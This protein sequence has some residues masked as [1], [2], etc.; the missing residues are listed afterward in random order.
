MRIPRVHLDQPLQSGKR[1][2]LDPGPA[3][4]LLKVLRLRPGAKLALFNGDGHDYPA[5]LLGGGEVQLDEAVTMHS[6]S[7]LR[8]TLAQGLCRGERMDLVLQKATELGLHTLQPL[9]LL[10]SEVKLN[11]DRLAR[12]QQHW[13]QVLRSACEQCGRAQLPQLLETLTL[14]NWLA[15]LPAPADDELRV[16]LDPDGD[17]SL[18]ALPQ[19]TRII[20]V[21][22]PEGGLDEREIELCAQVGFHRLRL[23]PRI[24]RTETA[25]PALIAAA[26]GLWGDLGG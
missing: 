10:R 9:Q 13:Q 23:G 26:L 21:I 22:G 6:E 20:A 19:P 12:R 25:G 11:A 1:V 8:I 7:A 5:E 24:L 14:A 3:H 16:V 4:H 15:A 2:R 17:S 18:R